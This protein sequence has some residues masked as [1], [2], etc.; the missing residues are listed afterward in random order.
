MEDGKPDGEQEAPFVD[1]AEGER[2]FL[3]EDSCVEILEDSPRLPDNP[4]PD[5]TIQ[6]AKKKGEGALTPWGEGSFDILGSVRR[7]TCDS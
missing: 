6:A 3:R 1:Q 2:I 4:H 7:K 5:A